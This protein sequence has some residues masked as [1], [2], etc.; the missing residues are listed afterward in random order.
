MD[1]FELA[2]IFGLLV[3]IIAVMY[4]AHKIQKLHDHVRHLRQLVQKLEGG[5]EEDEK[6]GPEDEGGP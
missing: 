5:P 3:L 1:A 6:A 2:L 4:L